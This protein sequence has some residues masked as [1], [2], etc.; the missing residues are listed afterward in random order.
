M[1]HSAL[2]RALC[3]TAVLIAAFSA[4]GRG[5]SDTA[6][7]DSAPES[8]AGE[9]ANLQEAYPKAY[10][11]QISPLPGRR[12]KPM[13]EWGIDNGQTF[14]SHTFSSFSNPMYPPDFPH[15]DYVNPD[16]PQGGTLRIA[17]Q[18]TYDTF[19]QYGQRGDFHGLMASF[20]NTLMTGSADEIDALY[21]LIAEKIEYAKDFSYVIFHINPLA[22]FQDGAPVTA[23][24]AVFSFNKFFDEGVPQ[25]ANYY[26]TVSRVEAVE[27]LKVRFDLEEPSR[28]I[29]AGLAGLVIVPRQFWENRDFS[30]P[31]Q[32]VP[33]GSGAWTV[34]DY[35]M[36][37]F[38]VFEQI[39]DYWAADLP[40]SRG[41][42]NFKNIKLD[43]Y[44]DESV[45]LEAFK[46]GEYDFRVENIAKNWA[47]Q[48]EGPLIESGSIIKAPF[49]NTAPPT[50][51]GMVFNTSIDL[52]SDYR[53]RRAVSYA[54]DFEW[55]NKNLFFDQ[56]ARSRSYFQGTDYEARGL[57]S[58]QELDILEPIRDQIPPEVFTDAYQPPVTD[59]S[60]S[61]RGEIREALSLF[62]Q[63]GWSLKDGV[64][65]NDETGEPFEFEFIIWSPS[66]ERVVLP[67][68][69]NLKKMGITMNIAL[70]DSTQFIERLRDGEFEMLSWASAPS[71]YPSNSIK[72]AW[73]SDFIDS[74][75]N[76]PRVT[77]PAVD[78]LVDGILDSQGDKE[79]LIHWGRAFD[80]VVQWQN[81]YIFNWHLAYFR[82]AH[83]DK[84]GKPDVRPKYGSGPLAW[85][86]WW[87][88]K[89]KLQA[90]PENLR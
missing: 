89:E 88:D 66:T 26:S 72:I 40:V 53:V 59:G 81:Y 52:F 31:L 61:I 75:Y 5:D 86:Y 25:F 30:E 39:D 23:E 46:A 19:H 57:P 84:F 27:R 49:P 6:G 24:D 67:L 82:A 62:E 55:M 79:T 18:G 11:P 48:Y 4:Y 74:S 85:T 58:P 65:R 47:T 69:E 2:K 1:F 42:G 83:L 50:R 63:A 29:I 43:F 21:P 68:Q 71:L 16:A 41:I 78:Y 22:R 70:L 38:I 33:L 12:G 36:G 8:A 32:E 7:T 34:S 73:R 56:Y 35:K 64:L 15:F 54:M 20:Y 77:D 76:T 90:L 37:S 17:A 87:V 28:E 51:Q 10:T 9:S 45:L 3:I 44:K 14:I 80:R 60:G 13:E